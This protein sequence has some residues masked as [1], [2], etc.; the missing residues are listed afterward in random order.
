[1]NQSRRAKIIVN[2]IS[3]LVDEK[4]KFAYW[5]EKSYA[6]IAYNREIQKDKIEA[7]ETTLLGQIANVLMKLEGKCSNSQML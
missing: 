7:I 4:I 1:M 6:E 3:R 5:D 2:T